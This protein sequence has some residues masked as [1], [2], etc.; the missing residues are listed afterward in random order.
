LRRGLDE[1]THRLDLAER[2]AAERLRRH[3]AAGFTT[4]TRSIYAH[5]RPPIQRLSF[6]N[7]LRGWQIVGDYIFKMFVGNDDYLPSVVPAWP[8]MRPAGRSG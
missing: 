1:T 6:R 3:G 2:D 5:C 4:L 7:S 8:Q